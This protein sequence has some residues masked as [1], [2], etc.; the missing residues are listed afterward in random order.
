MANEKQG[1]A[2]RPGL[3]ERNKLVKR[4]RIVGSAW[5]LFREKGFEA[6]TMREI[7]ERA[8]VGAGT[9]FVYA[10]SKSDLLV[11]VYWEAIRDTVRKAFTSLPKGGS[12][13]DELMHVFTRLFD[14]YARDVELSRAYVREVIF[15]PGP[16]RQEMDELTML[17]FQTAAE[18]MGAARERG[19]VGDHFD[20]VAAARNIFGLYFFALTG[21]LGGWVDDRKVALASLRAAVELQVEGLRPKAGRVTKSAARSK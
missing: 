17:F 6:A 16:T 15:S 4:E 11:L 2:A 10:K 14:M 9:V 8:D 20:P 21:W 3:R 7:A 1:Q 18:R 12:L 13:V 5:E 19:E